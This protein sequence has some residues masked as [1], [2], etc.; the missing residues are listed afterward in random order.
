[1]ANLSGEKFFV[2]PQ[3]TAF[4]TTDGSVNNLLY[5]PT[6]IH[7]FHV[8]GFRI[9]PHHLK[10]GFNFLSKAPLEALCRCKPG[11]HSHNLV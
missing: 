5:L 2:K 3:F 6:I 7:E 9:L 4:C 1:M 8:A 11:R 10:R